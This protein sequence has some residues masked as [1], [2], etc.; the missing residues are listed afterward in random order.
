[1]KCFLNLYCMYCLK[2]SPCGRGRNSTCLEAVIREITKN[3]SSGLKHIFRYDRSNSVMRVYA[4]ML[5][6]IFF[7]YYVQRFNPCH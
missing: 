5:S 3:T 4:R 2:T 1:M 7:L 6:H